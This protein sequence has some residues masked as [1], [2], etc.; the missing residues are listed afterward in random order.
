MPSDVFAQSWVW[1]I[2]S[3]PGK[4]GSITERRRRACS[5]AIATGI[6]PTDDCHVCTLPPEVHDGKVAPDISPPKTPGALRSLHSIDRCPKTK[7]ILNCEITSPPHL[8][9][10]FTPKIL[11][12]LYHTCPA[13]SWGLTAAAVVNMT[14][15]TT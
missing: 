15:R 9:R 10:W 5:N 3:Q 6:V 4:A 11:P 8:R 13:A 7:Y 14:R 1:E 2:S 12:A